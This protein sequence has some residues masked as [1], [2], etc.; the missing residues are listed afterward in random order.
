MKTF[1]LLAFLLMMTTYSNAYHSSIVP[2]DTIPDIIQVKPSTGLEASSISVISGTGS[3]FYGPITYVMLL[4]GIF[5]NWVFI[6][7]IGWV[8]G[9]VG[10]ISGI[11][12]LSVNHKMLQT[13]LTMEGKKTAKRIKRRS[14]AGIIF[15][16]VGI[17]I[18]LILNALDSTFV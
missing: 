8:I 16:I 10:I 2:N 5:D 14:I 7:T 9:L 13:N 4:I 6:H 12:G 15:G 18:P 3:L 17:L 11:V 1:L